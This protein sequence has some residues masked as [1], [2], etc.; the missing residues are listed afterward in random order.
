MNFNDEEFTSLADKIMLG[1]E[2]TAEIQEFIERW[3]QWNLG[4]PSWADNLWEMLSL[5][6]ERRAEVMGEWK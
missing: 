1:K 6:P 5:P 3:F 4:D 2:G